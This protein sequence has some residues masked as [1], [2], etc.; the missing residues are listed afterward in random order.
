MELDRILGQ[1]RALEALK[2]ALAKG[3]VP[4]AWL[5]EG[6]D[7]VGKEKAALAFAMALTCPE[8][9]MAGCGTCASCKRVGKRLHPDVTFVLPEDEQ[10]QRGWAGRSDFDHTPSRDIRVEQV[11]QLQERLAFRALEAP[12]KVAL[13]LGAHAMNPQAQNALLKTLEEPPKGTVLVLVS[14]A[15]DKLL[16]TIRSRCTKALFAPLNDEA[17]A[18]VLVAEDELAEADAKK[19]AALAGGSIARARR[20]DKD[21]LA[22]RKDTVERFE[23]LRKDDARG[24]LAFAE[25]A[26]ESRGIAES[27]LEVLSQWLHEVACAQVGAPLDTELQPLALEAASRHTPFALHRRALLVDE[28][29][30]AITARNGGIRLQLERMLIEMH[31]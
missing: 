10:V 4:H 23:A 6:P 2:G 27:C 12:W 1:P 26:A 15:S 18:K 11:R 9:P 20:L 29:R 14:S 31:A 5:F 28:A 3:A 17:L 22:D 13:L 24:W 30:L 8:K 16:P 21:A 19:V 25:T 7:G